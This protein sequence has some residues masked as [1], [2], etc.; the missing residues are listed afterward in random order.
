MR[1]F[2]C[3][4]VLAFVSACASAPSSRTG[5]DVAWEMP[6]DAH[7]ARL[8]FEN[9][10]PRAFSW[11]DGERGPELVL[12]EPARWEA[13]VRAPQAIALCTELAF[14]EFTLDVEVAQT[15]REYPHRDL[16]LYFGW[17]DAAHFG[18]VHLS[19]AADENAHGVFLV[20]GAPRRQVT[21]RRDAGIAWGAP[22]AWHRV[23]LERRDGRV[24][25]FVDGAS[26]AVM[27]ADAAPFRDGFCGVG[28]FDDVGAFRALRIRG[29]TVPRPDA[30]PFA[31]R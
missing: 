27:E 23:R 22:D 6:A 1:A 20:D 7:G 13:P 11:R 4:G 29:K 18:Y 30:A 16:C 19:S 12:A 9:S 31:S 5:E 28:S 14:G 25:V 2:G 10:D 21:A 24:R 15:G 17:R 26:E 8:A 3:V